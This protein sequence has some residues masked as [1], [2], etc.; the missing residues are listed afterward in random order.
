[1]FGKQR[2]IKNILLLV[3]F[4][5]I[6]GL[7]HYVCAAQANIILEDGT[8]LDSNYQIKTVWRSLYFMNVLINILFIINIVLFKVNKKP[9]NKKVRIILILIMLIDWL[10]SGV[11][12]RGAQLAPYVDW[13][14]TSEL[15]EIIMIGAV[16][17]IILIYNIIEK[18]KTQNK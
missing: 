16:Q 6:F 15:M 11:V 2:I 7:T 13:S 4:I 1:M 10:L 18:V 5:S 3:L 12:L 14:P 9:I 8:V 17:L